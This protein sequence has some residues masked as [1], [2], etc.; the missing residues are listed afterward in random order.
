MSEAELDEGIS[1]EDGRRKK[2][3]PKVWVAPF[4][5]LEFFTE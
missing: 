5:D 4:Y 1:R 2:N 3:L